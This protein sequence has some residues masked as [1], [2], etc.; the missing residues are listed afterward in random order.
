M[1]TK[2]DPPNG[3]MSAPGKHYFMLWR[4][5]FEV[6]LRYVPIKPIG[7]GAYGIVCSARDAN[8][9]AKVAIKRNTNV[10]ENTTDARRTLREIKLLR[11]LFH[12]NIIAVKDIMV[13]SSKHAFKDLYVVYELMD[14]DLHQIIRSSQL[15]NDDHYQYLIYQV[16]ILR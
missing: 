9:G 5:I 15:L 1:A 7:K 10:F 6:D 8:T 16:Y 2:I 13:P 3:A 12:E 14:T 11:H 4:T